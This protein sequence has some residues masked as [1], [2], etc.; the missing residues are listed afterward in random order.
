MIKF[1]NTRQISQGISG[2]IHKEFNAGVE[3]FNRT[4]RAWRI[5][6]II[7][8]KFFERSTTMSYKISFDSP[9]NTSHALSIKLM[10][11]EPNFMNEFLRKNPSFPTIFA[12]KSERESYFKVFFKI[13]FLFFLRKKTGMTNF[14]RFLDCF[15]LLCRTRN[16]ENH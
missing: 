12:R 4:H 11:T 2:Y 13:P 16:D 10:S 9:E 14:V 5:F 8:R 3:N 7:V 15:V 6:T 1:S